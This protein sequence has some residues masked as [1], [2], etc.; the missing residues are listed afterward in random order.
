MVT[1]QLFVSLPL[2]RAIEH[3]PE[4]VEVDGLTLRFTGEVTSSPIVLGFAAHRARVECDHGTGHV[5]LS[6]ATSWRSEMTLR[7]DGINARRA[8]A[9][10][11]A[12]RRAMVAEQTR[13]EPVAGERI[14]VCRSA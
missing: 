5:D 9:L 6:S 8:E 12:L 14:A 1:K 3:L 13:V 11:Q 2:L 4:A 10:V 7:I